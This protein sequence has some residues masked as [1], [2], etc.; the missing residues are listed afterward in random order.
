MNTGTVRPPTR[1]R[2][3]G[4]VVS[5]PEPSWGA[6]AAPIVPVVDR[7]EVRD[8]DHP[9]DPDGLRDLSHGWQPEDVYRPRVGQRGWPN[10]LTIPC[11]NSAP[12]HRRVRRHGGKDY[13]ASRI[14]AHSVMSP[15]SDVFNRR[16]LTWITSIVAGQTLSRCPQSS[17]SFHRDPA[18]FAYG[19]LTADLVPAPCYWRL[20]HPG[21]DTKSSRN[22]YLETPRTWGC[23][24]GPHGAP[25]LSVTTVLTAL[26]PS[27]RRPRSSIRRR[28]MTVLEPRD[29]RVS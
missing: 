4:P 23:T 6:L 12:G 1:R 9:R 13:G 15:I 26:A 20:P 8:G 29:P 14:P 22:R 27:F 28:F 24:R 2:R 18:E 10:D 17:I 3:L 7:F 16:P 25:R 19:L 21:S 5:R 11:G